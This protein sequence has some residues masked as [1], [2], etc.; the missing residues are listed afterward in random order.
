MSP[1]SRE[2]ESFAPRLLPAMVVIAALIVLAGLASLHAAAQAPAG[3]A[4][5]D[6][7]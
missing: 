1:T 6:T 4:I 7:L 5:V 2:P 3:V